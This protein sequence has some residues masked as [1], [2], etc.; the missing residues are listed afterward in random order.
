[1]TLAQLIAQAIATR[2]IDVSAFNACA[3]DLAVARDDLANLY[4]REVATGYLEGRYAWQDGDD[5][6]NALSSLFN[7]SYEG[8]R[9]LALNVFIAFDEGE[10]IHQG[11]EAHDG[12]PRTR[13]LLTRF[14]GHLGA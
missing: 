4:A 2:R 3:R 6:M 5:A 10:Y 11:D 14:V 12:E 9:G 13:S 1:L 8:L 7:L